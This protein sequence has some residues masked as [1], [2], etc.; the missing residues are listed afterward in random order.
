MNEFLLVVCGLHDCRRPWD[1]L[2]TSQEELEGAIP[3]GLCVR[4]GLRLSADSP[5]ALHLLFLR[6]DQC[7]WK[8]KRVQ[9][10]LRFYESERCE[11][12]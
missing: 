11:T 1:G 9:L 4:Y 3:P 8:D 6:N 5:R 7:Q 10:K 12:N 2:G